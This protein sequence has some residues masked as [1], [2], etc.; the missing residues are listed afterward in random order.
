[1]YSFFKLLFSYFTTFSR[2][3]IFFLKF[4]QFFLKTERSPSKLLFNSFSSVTKVEK[5]VVLGLFN[6]P[7][8]DKMIFSSIYLISSSVLTLFLFIFSAYFFNSFSYIFSYVMAFI[9][10]S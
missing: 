10:F 9:I 3:F 2:F 7:I 8:A 6:F 5:F 1:M 4:S